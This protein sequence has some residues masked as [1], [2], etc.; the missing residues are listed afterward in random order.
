MDIRRYSIESINRGNRMAMECLE[1][2]DNCKAVEI[3]VAEVY[4]EWINQPTV[5]TPSMIEQSGDLDPSNPEEFLSWV[6]NL[7]QGGTSNYY[8]MYFAEF[9]YMGYEYNFYWL[10]SDGS[11]YR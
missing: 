10:N 7:E 4:R 11:F 8:G 9:E 3:N 2:G 5:F 6:E 1:D